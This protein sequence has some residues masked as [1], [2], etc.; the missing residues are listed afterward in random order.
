VKGLST[1]IDTLNLA[2]KGHVRAEVWELLSEA[3]QQARLEEESQPVEFPMT[4]QA[5]L[6]KPHGLRGH[7]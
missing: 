5:F 1:G 6:I 4:G 7:A 3:R 2:A